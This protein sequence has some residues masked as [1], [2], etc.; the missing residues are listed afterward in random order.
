MD[1][2]NAV[3]TLATIRLINFATTTFSF[4]YFTR[5]WYYLSTPHLKWR[6]ERKTMC[7]RRGE[8][9]GKKKERGVWEVLT[10]FS[11]TKSGTKS[12]PN[13]VSLLIG[14]LFTRVTIDFVL[15]LF[16]RWNLKVVS[17]SYVLQHQI[18][19]L[20]PRK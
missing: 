12:K 6:T 2:N 20:T 18:H 1:A 8:V 4:S 5:T 16:D 9:E 11:C 10:F 19:I 7:E 3:T 15:I 13:N 14:D 17:K